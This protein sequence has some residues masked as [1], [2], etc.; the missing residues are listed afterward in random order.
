MS[1]HSRCGTVH[2]VIGVEMPPEEERARLFVA[3]L[4]VGVGCG[5]NGG[6]VFA[7]VLTGRLTGLKIRSK[8][9]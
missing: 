9:P 3:A 7:P 5:P 2:I 1:S 4:L 8:S 6:K